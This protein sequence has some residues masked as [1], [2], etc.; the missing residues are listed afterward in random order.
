M[1]FL[2][3]YDEKNYFFTVFIKIKNISRKKI[4]SKDSKRSYQYTSPYPMEKT[5][6]KKKDISRSTRRYTTLF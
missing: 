1:A 3:K 2:M 4:V 6:N 5:V